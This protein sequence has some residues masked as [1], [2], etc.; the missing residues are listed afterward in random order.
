MKKIALLFAFV[1]SSI[2]I[3]AAPPKL[4]IPTEIFVKA[5]KWAQVLPDTECKKITYVSHDGLDPYPAEEQVNKLKMI[6]FPTEDNKRYK[7]TAVGSLNDEH[8]VAEFWLVVGKPKEDGD[9]KPVPV[10]PPPVKP[11]PTPSDKSFFVIARMDGPIDPGLANALLMPGWEELKRLG[12]GVKSYPF[13]DL[14]QDCKDQIVTGTTMPCVFK[15]AM[16]KDGKGRAKAGKPIDFPKDNDA[17]LALT[18]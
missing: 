4:T 5:G 7:F 2:P 9:T 18:K 15:L 16:N 13:K 14:P 6:V 12:H 17:V 10:E 11:E 1:L 8:V 3:S